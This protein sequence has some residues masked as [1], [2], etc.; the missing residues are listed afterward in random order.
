MRQRRRRGCNRSRR[1][2]NR[3]EHMRQRRR[4]G[5]NRRSRKG[6]EEES[7]GDVFYRMNGKY[8]C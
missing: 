2:D 1:G 3:D 7:V 4:R 8:P 5:Y 6:G